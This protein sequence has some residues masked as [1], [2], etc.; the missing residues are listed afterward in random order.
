MM[1]S[2]LSLFSFQAFQKLDLELLYFWL[3][4]SFLFWSGFLL[5]FSNMQEFLYM[6]IFKV[7]SLSD[8]VHGH[9]LQCDIF[10]L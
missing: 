8:Q 7:R 3:F 10:N 2:M 5:G 1:S 9:F 4:T 6:R